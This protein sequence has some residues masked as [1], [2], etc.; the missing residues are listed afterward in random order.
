[1]DFITTTGLG[2]QFEGQNVLTGINLTVSKGEVLALIG[3]TGA[4]KTTLLRL[5]DLLEI[6]SAGM[7]HFDGADVT[8]SASSRL[9]ARRRMSF[10]QQKPIVFTMNVYDNI[11]CGLK[12]RHAK[13]SVIR[14]KVAGT[15]EMVDMTA[16]KHRNAKT[17]SGGET[18]RLAIAR[19]LITDPEVLFLD[20]PTANLDPIS[21]TKVEEVL[22][23]IIRKQKITVVM[24][25]HD[26]PQGQRI[27]GRISVL[28]NGKVLQTGTPNEIFCLPNSR[29]VA[30][31]IGVENILGGTV[32]EKDA[33]LVTVAINGNRIQAISDY[34]VSD[35]VYAII[36]PEDITFT[37]TRDT[38]SA[39]NVFQGTIIRMAPVGPLV[40]VE[41]DCGFSLLG[42]VTGKSASELGFDIG[43]R[44]YASFKATAIHTIKRWD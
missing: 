23:R 39:R 15:L 26:M 37:L 5:L 2:Q 38:S 10:V 41:V 3:P 42:V 32:I 21:T 25:T 35:R 29:E 7:I 34:A 40:R 6:P 24:A 44:I 8:R 16:Y 17:L 18:Q 19:A 36:R 12:W 9:E 1:M 30:E 33:N 27:A 4:G 11:A 20:E 28:M 14:Q 13:N 43:K 22:A 31:F